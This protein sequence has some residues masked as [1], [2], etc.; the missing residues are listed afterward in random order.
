MIEIKTDHVAQFGGKSG[1]LRQP[2][3]AHAVR[4]QAVRRQ[5]RCTDPDDLDPLSRAALWQAIVFDMDDERRQKRL[6]NASGDGRII[7][8]RCGATLATYAD[9]C[10][11]ENRHPCPGDLAMD[12][13]EFG[14]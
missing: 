7:C 9:A 12:K 5:M 13:A 3:P 14:N 4:L 2:E 11:A 6:E 1:I 10:T 8:E